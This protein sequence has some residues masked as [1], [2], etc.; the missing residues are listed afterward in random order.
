[1]TPHL[2]FWNICVERA[3]W[4]KSHWSFWP[5]SF[6]CSHNLRLNLPFHINELLQQSMEQHYILILKAKSFQEVSKTV[7]EFFLFPRIWVQTLIYT[8]N[9][10]K[11]LMCLYNPPFSASVAKF[12]YLLCFQS[13]AFCRGPCQELGGCLFPWAVNLLTVLFPLETES[14]YKTPKTRHGWCSILLWEWQFP[15]DLIIRNN[16]F[17]LTVGKKNLCI[18]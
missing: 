18:I 9:S 7:L 11:R 1:M 13:F 3:C 10:S 17:G 16:T 6:Q 14:K 2:H 12:L 5:P 15:C 4:V 8:K